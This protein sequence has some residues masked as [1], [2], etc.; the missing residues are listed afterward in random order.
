[1]NTPFRPATIILSAICLM[2]LGAA[3]AP[4]PLMRDP[5]VGTWSV[6]VTPDNDARHDGEKDFKETLIFKGATFEATV[7]KKH[8]F[9]AGPYEEDIRQG[10]VGA[11]TAV[12][13]SKTGEGTANWSGSV[14][15]VDMRGDLKWTKKDGTVENYTFTGTKD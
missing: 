1:M 11:F 15:A 2:L 14:M 10:G 3:A 8:G 12:Q 9:E 5:L 7:W 6:T 4:T 13:N